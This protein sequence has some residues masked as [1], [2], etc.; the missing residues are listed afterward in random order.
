MHLNRHNSGVS[1]NKRFIALDL[2]PTIVGFMV[3]A[4]VLMAA[5]SSDESLILRASKFSLRYCVKDPIEYQL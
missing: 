4:N 1:A 3:V 2:P 5:T